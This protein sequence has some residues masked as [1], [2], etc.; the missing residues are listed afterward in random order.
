MALKIVLS[1]FADER[2]ESHIVQVLKDVQPEIL[3][4]GP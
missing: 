3:T 2:C 1:E 4:K